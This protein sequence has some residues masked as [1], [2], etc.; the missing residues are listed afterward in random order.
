MFS[1]IFLLFLEKV[2]RFSFHVRTMDYSSVPESPMCILLIF[3]W[4]GSLRNPKYYIEILV[5]LFSAGFFSLAFCVIT[6]QA[7]SIAEQGHMFSIVS[8]A[9]TAI[10]TFSWIVTLQSTAVWL[11]LN[12][13]LVPSYLLLDCNWLRYV[14]LHLVCS[15]STVSFPRTDMSAYLTKIIKGCSSAGLSAESW[16]MSVAG[17]YLYHAQ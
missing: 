10:C 12:F 13:H 1:D 5:I 4:G 14:S 17:I 16:P 9:T 6:V 2:Y 8:L 15:L 7:H 3:P 11:S